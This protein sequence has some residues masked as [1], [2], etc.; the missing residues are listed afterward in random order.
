MI[1]GAS[2]GSFKGLTLQDGTSFYLELSKEFDI[3]AVEIR[4]EK[5]ASRPCMWP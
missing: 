3:K 1:I 2:L 5:K 4:L